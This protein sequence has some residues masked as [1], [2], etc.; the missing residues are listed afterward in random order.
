MGSHEI[1]GRQAIGDMQPR[2]SPL[3]PLFNDKTTKSDA[4]MYIVTA[5]GIS[6]TAS[7]HHQYSVLTKAGST[8]TIGKKLNLSELDS[9]GVQLTSDASTGL[10]DQFRR[11]HKITTGASAGFNNL[12]GAQQMQQ[13]QPSTASAPGS[14]PM[15]S[16]QGSSHLATTGRMQGG[17]IRRGASSAGMRGTVRGTSAASFAGV[18]MPTLPPG[19]PTIPSMPTMPT[20]SSMNSSKPVSRTPSLMETPQMPSMN[21]LPGTKDTP[22]PAGSLRGMPVIADI[23]SSSLPR[24]SK[25]SQ[26]DVQTSIPGPP[27]IYI[28]GPPP[29][30]GPTAPAGLSKS[31]LNVYL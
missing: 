16:S 14:A 29:F 9:V 30:A 13:Q 21:P 7:A 3:D 12:S 4:P 19:M 8:S 17:T 20:V 23:S 6:G 15:S 26:D 27:S 24:P 1:A 25:Q 18:E 28:P 31:S 2:T 5:Q 11:E 22:S 10:C